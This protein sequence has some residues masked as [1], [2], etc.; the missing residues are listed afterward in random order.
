MNKKMNKNKLRLILPLLMIFIMVPSVLAYTV[1]GIVK[2][3]NI[4]PLEGATVVI[5][6]FPGA[7]EVVPSVLT[8]SNG[9]Y[10][11]VIPGLSGTY[12]IKVPTYLTYSEATSYKYIDEYPDPVILDFTLGPAS[13]ITLSGWVNDSDG[14][15]LENVNIMIIVGE[16]PYTNTKTNAL[17]YYSVE[18]LDNLIY[19]IKASL[20]GYIVNTKPTQAL[21]VN[22]LDFD[23]TL[24]NECLDGDGDGYIELSCGGTDCDDANILINPNIV[25]ICG[26]GIDEDC[27]GSDLL[28]GGGSQGSSGGGG[29][30]S[31]PEVVTSTP[32]IT[33]P[34]VEDQAL[35]TE[36]TNAPG[37]TGATVT[38]TGSGNLYIAG[39][40]V[41][42]LLIV[43]FFVW[44]KYK[45]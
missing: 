14:N 3:V 31:H 12:L 10:T 24:L 21:G 33:E 39:F 28:C 11:F 6:T 26:N 13:H 16:G 2:G 30:N 43:G 23:F 42:L 32:I 36:D 7:I 34:I 18:I 44:K 38:N 1:T 45:K 4:G 29:S 9:I 15:P 8:D 37:I 25:E 17:G 41:L 27:S 19:N 20:V 40:L 22:I 5:E 35:Q